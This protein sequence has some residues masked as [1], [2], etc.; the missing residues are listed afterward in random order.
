MRYLWFSLG[1]AAIHLGAYVV[2]GVLTQVWSKD[3]GVSSQRP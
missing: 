3:P 1:F 2:A